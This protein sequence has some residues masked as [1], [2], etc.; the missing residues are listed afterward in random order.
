MSKNLIE[1]MSNVS[2]MAPG[3]NTVSGYQVAALLRKDEGERT[4]GKKKER[5]ASGRKKNRVCVK[6]TITPR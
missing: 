3:R 6:V 1:C 5:S 2:A 4:D